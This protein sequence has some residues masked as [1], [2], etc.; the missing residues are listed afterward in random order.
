VSNST[1][2]VDPWPD[3]LQTAE[4]ISR[5]DAEPEEEV[6]VLLGVDPIGQQ[7]ARL[8]GQV[9]LTQLLE[10]LQDRS[11]V[12]EQREPPRATTVMDAHGVLPHT[13]YPSP[14]AQL[15]AMRDVPRGRR[16]RQS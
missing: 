12:D 16:Q 3:A 2:V 15:T 8:F 5:V 11:F 10:R 13:C 14:A 6:D 9:V 1:L 7:R 4:E